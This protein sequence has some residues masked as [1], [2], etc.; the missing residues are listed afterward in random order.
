MIAQIQALS[1]DKLA[2]FVDL[3]EAYV[4]EQRGMDEKRKEA[5]QREED[6]A[7]EREGQQ[8][9]RQRK[10]KEESNKNNDGTPLDQWTD[11]LEKYTRILAQ[12]KQTGKKFTDTDFKANDESLGPQLRSRVKVDKWIRAS[13]Q[14]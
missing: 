8:A 7:R 1:E 14:V 12:C 9:D 6:K 11:C 3:R 5:A 13:D 4:A 10:R 2:M